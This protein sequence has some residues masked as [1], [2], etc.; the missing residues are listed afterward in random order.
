MTQ[1]LSLSLVSLVDCV[2][3]L[4]SEQDSEKVGIYRNM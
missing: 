3:E 4:F 2:L 1:F